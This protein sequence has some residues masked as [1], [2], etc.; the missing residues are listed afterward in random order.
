MTW[1]NQNDQGRFAL[2]DLSFIG[3]NGPSFPFL[4][5]LSFILLNFIV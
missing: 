2:E 4:P 5:L 3:Y 1:P